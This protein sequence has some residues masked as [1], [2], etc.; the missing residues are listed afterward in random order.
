MYL[1]ACPPLPWPSP[2]LEPHVQ[3]WRR[4][5]K[6]T[7]WRSSKSCGFWQPRYNITLLSL[8]V[9]LNPKSE[10]VISR[11]FSMNFSNRIDES[12][13]FFKAFQMVITKTPRT[14]KI[15]PRSSRYP[16]GSRSTFR[17]GSVCM[18]FHIFF[19]GSHQTPLLSKKTK[20]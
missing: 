2:C 15:A 14:S 1:T 11:H 3:A 18:S 13:Q 9:D 4:S 19:K 20:T 6:A 8:K 7:V 17:E 10:I 16:P 12:N 5:A